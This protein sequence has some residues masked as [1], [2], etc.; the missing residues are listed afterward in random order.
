MSMGG[1]VL[2]VYIV[3]NYV[4]LRIYSKNAKHRVMG[5]FLTLSYRECTANKWD[6]AR[7]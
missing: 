2:F 7:C 4:K 3:S 5:F 1:G 6:S